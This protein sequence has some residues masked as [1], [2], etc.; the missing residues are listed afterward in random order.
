MRRTVAEQ[1]AMRLGRNRDG[2]AVGQV[3]ANIAA[4]VDT[5][6]LSIGVVG[7]RTGIGDRRRGNGAGVDQRVG[8]IRTRQA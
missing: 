5:I 4:G 3:A 2:A 6:G 1:A 8:D 7:A